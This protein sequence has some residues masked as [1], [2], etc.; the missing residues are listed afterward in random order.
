MCERC[1]VC[2]ISVT[3]YCEIQ[4]RVICFTYYYDK[5]GKE[6]K[7]RPDCEREKN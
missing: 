5:N 2:K 3:K 7:E 1:N 6:L 4:R